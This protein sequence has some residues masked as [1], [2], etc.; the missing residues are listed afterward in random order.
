MKRELE[1]KKI[2]LTFAF[3]IVTASVSLKATGLT[4]LSDGEAR[5]VGKLLGS[6]HLALAFTA[7]QCANLAHKGFCSG[8]P[9]LSLIPDKFS[10]LRGDF[11]FVDEHKT[12]FGCLGSLGVLA[13][14]TYYGV[15]GYYGVTD[16]FQDKSQRKVNLEKTRLETELLR[17]KLEKERNGK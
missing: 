17:L 15:K 16:F 13:I 14:G 4:G 1:V 7:I 12:A 6:K 2:F 3:L 9:F 8:K 5:I 11:A 10:W